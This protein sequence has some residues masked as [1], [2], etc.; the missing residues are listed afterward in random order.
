MR[1]ASLNP[2]LVCDLR[3]LG[4]INKFAQ[5]IFLSVPEVDVRMK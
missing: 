3:R 5:G 2:A 1:D 4:A